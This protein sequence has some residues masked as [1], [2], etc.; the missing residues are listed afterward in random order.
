M[1]R[2]HAMQYHTNLSIILI[3]TAKWPNSPVVV[4]QS[5]HL[6]EDPPRSQGFS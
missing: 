2:S 5:C 4:C 6:G 1:V 3:I